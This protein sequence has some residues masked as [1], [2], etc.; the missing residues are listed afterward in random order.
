M[1]LTTFLTISTDNVSTTIAYIKDL[2]GDLMPLLL[3]VMAVG[4]G[5]IIFEVIVSVIRGRK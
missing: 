1:I 2:I 5:L 4:I 3:I